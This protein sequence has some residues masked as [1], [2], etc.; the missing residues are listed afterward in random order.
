MIK[1]F[2]KKRVFCSV[3]HLFLF[4]SPNAAN[5][6]PARATFTAVQRTSPDITGTIPRKV[7]P[8]QRFALSLRRCCK[9][10]VP[11]W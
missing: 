10:A 1:D 3:L 6:V 8:R 9:K 4:L 11:E 2:K 5:A 7:V